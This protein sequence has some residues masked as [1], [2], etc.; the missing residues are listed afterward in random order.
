MIYIGWVI[1][2][3]FGLIMGM[4]IANEFAVGKNKDGLMGK[5]MNHG[6]KDNRKEEMK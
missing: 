3:G 4:V 5:N 1:A 2:L 6:P